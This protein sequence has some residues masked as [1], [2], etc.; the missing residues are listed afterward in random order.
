MNGILFRVDWLEF[1]PFISIDPPARGTAL[2]QIFL[3]MVPTEATNL[4][5]Y[6]NYLSRSSIYEGFT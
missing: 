4:F 3:D 5:R 6:I 1:H 2:V